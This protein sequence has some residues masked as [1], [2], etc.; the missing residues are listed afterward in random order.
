MQKNQF[1]E[2]RNFVTVAQAGSFTL[3]A[4]AL[5]MTGSALS[6]SIMRL[7]ARLG[8]KLLHRTTRRVSLTNDGDSYLCDCQ[9]AMAILDQAESRLGSEQRLPAGRVRIDLPSAFGRRYVL[10]ALLDLVRQ[11]PQLDLSVTFSDRPVDLLADGIDLAV[12]VGALDDNVDLVARRLGEQRRVIC[13]SPAYFAHRGLPQAREEL[14]QHA[15]ITGW[16]MTLRHSWLLSN[17][18]GTTEAFEIPVRHEI[19]DCEAILAAA[20][21]GSGLAQMPTW[22]VEEHLE[23][24]ALLSVLDDQA[25]DG[26]PIHA[27]WIKT[28]YIQPKLRVVIDELLR[29]AQAP[30]SRFRAG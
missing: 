24:G 29:L 9:N 10:P 3:A 11:Y 27:I 25:G 30:G 18:D 7:E 23:S 28:R 8:T 1:L 20:L 2:I 26:V 13:G 21:A 17:P 5:G 22:L 19:G 12:R 15:C 16:P 6:K 14:A 4:Q